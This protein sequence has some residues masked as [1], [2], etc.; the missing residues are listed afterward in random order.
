MSDDVA[1]NA[2]DPACNSIVFSETRALRTAVLRLR[3][4]PV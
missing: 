4:P 2:I 1:G 3:L